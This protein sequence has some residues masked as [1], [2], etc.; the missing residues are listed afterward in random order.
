[1]QVPVP[2]FEFGLTTGELVDRIGTESTWLHGRNQVSILKYIFENDRRALIFIYLMALLFRVAI[3]VAVAW[4]RGVHF[5]NAQIAEYIVS[6]QG[7]VWDWYKSIP[8]QPTAILPPIYTYF[9]AFF[10]AVFANPA[11][12][13]YL[14]QA[15]LNPLGIIPSF[16]LGKF[17]VD[18]KTGIIVAGL[19]ALFPEMAYAPTKMI[20]E[21]LALPLVILAIVLY[22][23]TKKGLESSM[24]TG[25]FFWLGLFLG[26]CALVKMTMSFILLSCVLGILLTRGISRLSIRSI[27]LMGIGFVIAVSP[28]SIRN[29]LVFDKFVPLR[30]MYGFNLW[31]GNHPGATGTPRIDPQNSVESALDPRYQKYIEDN[32]P[33]T[34]LELDRFYYE[35]AVRFIRENPAEFAWLTLKRIVYFITF[36]PTHPLTRNVVYLGG[37]LFLLI[38]GFW[39]AILLRKEKNLDNIFIVIPLVALFFYA[40]VVMLPR[41]R[42][43]FTMV[44]LLLSAIPIGKVFLKGRR[45]EFLNE[46]STR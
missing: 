42:L 15:I 29:T 4:N 20:S 36:D 46:P 34:E 3:I 1:V 13:I 5:E 2:G 31:R 11:R 8:P 16:Y 41:Y 37:R 19:F 18:R 22:L 38:F 40:P 30:T 43:F 23:K 14:A 39:G 12:W 45:L 17:L 28:W 44:L 6:G 25:G 33:Q 32:H 35:E 21:P 10:M 26:V 9:L 7:Y 24:K 27:V